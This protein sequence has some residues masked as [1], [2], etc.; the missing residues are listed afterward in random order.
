MVGHGPLADLDELVEAA[1]AVPTQGP[2]ERE[3]G[4]AEQCPVVHFDHHSAEFA[5]DPWTVYDGFATSA[6]WP[7]RTPMA[8]FTC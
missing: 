5:E 6:R 8:G 2:A 1:R 4:D 7:G 3:T